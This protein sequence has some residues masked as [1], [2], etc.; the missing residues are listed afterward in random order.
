MDTDRPDEE[1]VRAAE[2]EGLRISFVSQYY[3]EAQD[4]RQHVLV[5]NYS[6]LDPAKVPET[7]ERLAR[8]ILTEN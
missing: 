7:V 8:A 2:R 3:V 1:L 5:M 4:R 6:G